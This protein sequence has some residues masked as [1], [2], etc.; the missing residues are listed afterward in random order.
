MRHGWSAQVQAAGLSRKNVITLDAAIF[1]RHPHRPLG[2]GREQR[3]NVRRVNQCH[4][5]NNGGK[6]ECYQVAH[7]LRPAQ[8]RQYGIFDVQP[9]IDTSFSESFRSLARQRAVFLAMRNKYGLSF[10]RRSSARFKCV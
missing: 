6:Q 5:D 3:K 7:M 2:V 4:F 8:L 1:V 9:G 10:L